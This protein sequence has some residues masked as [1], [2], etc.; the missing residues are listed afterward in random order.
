VLLIILLEPAQNMKFWR[1]CKRQNYTLAGS[2]TPKV[3]EIRAKFGGKLCK[4]ASPLLDKIKHTGYKFLGGKI[5]QPRRKQRGM[6]VL[7]KELQSG[8]NTFLT[9][10]RLARESVQRVLNPSARINWMK[11]PKIWHILRYWR[12]YGLKMEYLFM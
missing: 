10:P 8:F 4:T 5:N 9:A 3:Y 12:R 1:C 7:N 11:K 6:V 2:Y